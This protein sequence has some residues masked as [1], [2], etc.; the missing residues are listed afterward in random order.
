MKQISKLLKENKVLKEMDLL[1]KL[2]HPNII[3]PIEL[4]EDA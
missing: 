4:F 1:I 3:K 2:D